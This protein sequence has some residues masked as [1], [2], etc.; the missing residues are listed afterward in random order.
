[1]EGDDRCDF[2][3]WSQYTSSN[4]TEGKYGRLLTEDQ[5]WKGARFCDYLSA[6]RDIDC[7]VNNFYSK[8]ISLNL[9]LITPPG[10]FFRVLN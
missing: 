10:K 7:C 4:L 3:P 1:M 2:S 9:T 5:N 8:F 6:Q